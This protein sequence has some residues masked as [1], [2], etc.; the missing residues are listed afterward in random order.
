MTESNSRRN[1]I[2][3]SAILA[4]ISPFVNFAEATTKPK[5]VKAKRVIQIFLPGGMAAQ[6]SFDPKPFNPYEYRG[7]YGTVKTSIPGIHFSENMKH[8]AKIADKI[9]VIRS[10]THGEAAHERGTHNMFTGYRPSPAI[11][12]PSIGAIVANQMGPRENMPPYIC[13]PNRPNEYAG[14]GYLSSMYSAFSLGADPS[15]KGFKV[16]DLKVPKGISMERFEQRK[17]ILSLVDSDFKKENQADAIKAMDSFYEKAFSLID[18]QKAQ[19]AFDID[20]EE[21]KI[22]DRYG[23]H[24][25]GQRFLMARRLVEAGARYVTVTAG[26]WDHHRN[27][28]GE[29]KKNLTPLDQALA[30]LISDLDERGMLDETLVTLTTEFG[31]TPKINKD[32]GR[33][34]YP[35]VFS[36]MM[37]GGGT[38]RGYVHGMSDTT[39]TAVEEAPVHTEDLAR[40]VYTLM[41][42]NPDTRLMAPGARP[43]PLVKDG[44]VIEDVLA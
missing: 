11:Q 20:K 37:A 28:R 12:F 27:I 26:G 1:F 2:R 10:M 36:I 6:E 5:V 22:K 19:E 43:I 44:E 14:T 13:I 24:Q 16:K 15:R 30:A 23:R 7:P 25:A 21:N 18:S 38:K 3:N 31:R 39:S 8:T 32:G 34:H 35:K 9:T 33:D 42:I 4:G 40:T 17:K 29:I 41:G